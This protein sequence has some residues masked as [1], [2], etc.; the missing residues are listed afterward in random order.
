MISTLAASELGDKRGQALVL[1]FRPA[2]LDHD[3]AAFDVAEV[4]QA[5]P[6]GAEEMGLESLGGVAEKADARELAGLLRGCGR[7]AQKPQRPAAR[8]SPA[9]SFDHL[10]GASEERRWDRQAERFGGGEVDDELKFR[11]LKDW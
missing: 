10:V 11:R 6:E 8:E 1:P 5:V 7:V 2:I 9:A 4:A 3:V